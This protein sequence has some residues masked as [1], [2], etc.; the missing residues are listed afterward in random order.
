VVNASVYESRGMTMSTSGVK[1]DKTERDNVRQIP[2]WTRRY[3][4]SRTVAVMVTFGFI[5]LF[6]VVIGGSSYWC[7][8]SYR[9]GQ[10][11]GFWV[12]LPVTVLGCVGLLLFSFKGHRL[13][14][15]I[16]ERYYAKEGNVALGPTDG[17]GGR[18]LLLVVA[19]AFGAC[20]VGSVVLGLLGYI[21]QEYMQ[22]VSALYMVPFMVFLTVKMR[23][24]AGF[25]PLLWPI[26]YTAHAVAIVVGFLPSTGHWGGA[27]M[28]IATVGY[29]LLSAL[30]A[31][32]INRVALHR[33]RRL[34][35]VEN[36]ENDGPE[37]EER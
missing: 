21:P 27:H 33:L 11:F 12:C 30:V 26:L 4:Q 31:H 29:G 24:V 25:L 10:M 16:S 14:Q 5:I 1:H 15:R 32:I 18:A 9:S 35:H 6:N 36:Q 8:R 34:A 22:P 2:K 20:I 28:M 19:G 13:I 7:G 3:A 17:E 37:V 23:A